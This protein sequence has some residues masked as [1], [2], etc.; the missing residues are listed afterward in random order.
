MHLTLLALA[1]LLAGNEAFRESKQED[2]LL[3][4]LSHEDHRDAIAAAAGD[5]FVTHLRHLKSARGVVVKRTQWALFDRDARVSEI[6]V[7]PGFARTKLAKTRG[8][9]PA[10]RPTAAPET[11]GDEPPL[12]AE[13]VREAAGFRADWWYDQSFPEGKPWNLD[14]IN[15]AGSLDGDVTR[16]VDGRGVNIF[17]MDTGLDAT[18]PAFAGSN[19]EVENVAD[20]ASSRPW[21]NKFE[22]GWYDPTP[23]RA[24]K[25][26]ND[27][28]SHGTHCAATAAGTTLGAAP[29]ANVYGM[30]ILGPD[31]GP[32]SWILEAFDAIAGLVQSGRLDGPAVIS[33]SFGGPCQ[34]SDV[35]YCAYRSW[36]AGAIQDLR[37]LGVATVVAAGNEGVDAC[38]GQPSAVREAITVGAIELGDRIADYSNWGSCIDVMAPGTDIPGAFS[39][40][41]EEY[42]YGFLDDGNPEYVVYEGTSMAA[43]LVAG[44]LALYL[45]IFDDAN[46]AVAAMLNN[47]EEKYTGSPSS[48]KTN[49]LIVRTPGTNDPSELDVSPIPDH[50]PLPGQEERANSCRY[51]FDGECD[52][53]LYCL[54]GTDTA[55]CAATIDTTPRPS[56]R[57]TPRPVAESPKPSP[58]PTPKPSPRPTSRPVADAPPATPKPTPRPVSTPRPSPKPTPRIKDEPDFPEESESDDQDGADDNSQDDAGS[59]SQ[60]DIP[61]VVENPE[62]DDNFFSFLDGAAQSSPAILVS[63]LAAVLALLL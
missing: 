62:D 44:A 60:D 55:D 22:W 20:F 16:E 37:A 17:V 19:R 4:R 48:C 43:P 53:P 8:P 28:D 58:R 33:G 29:R 10:P 50:C 21:K 14:R 32:V 38:T 57:P 52:E 34:S 1:G 23:T 3:L 40:R 25:E 63:L 42:G 2:H 56:P 24:S 13:A 61:L 41:A 11:A 26:N 59:A 54:Y 15:G 49:H 46:L 7:I 27:F 18:H 51:A 47:V 35:L 6:E 36:E 9:T 31:G 45:Q 12:T 39:D 5:G 30:R